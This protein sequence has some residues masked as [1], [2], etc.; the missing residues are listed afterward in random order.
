M[1]AHGKFLARMACHALILFVSATAHATDSPSLIDLRLDQENLSE[2]NRFSILPHKPNYIL[3]LSYNTQPNQAPWRTFGI[4]Q[5]PV[6]NHEVKFQVSIKLPLATN[7]L[8]EHDA[9][10]AAYTQKSFWQ[11]YNKKISSP[12]R[13]TSF[14]PELFYRMEL[15]REIAGLH[16]RILNLGF[17]HE[18][19][20]RAEPL[21]RSWNRLYATAVAEQGN[22]ALALKVWARIP[23]KAAS[24]NNPDILNYLGNEELYAIYHYE[25]HRFSLMFRPGLRAGFTPGIQL[26]WSFPLTEKIQGYVQYYSGY[27]ESLIDYNHYNNSIGIG[28]MLNN[29]L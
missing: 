4:G 29:W 25:R 16:V 14:N 12:F 2:K 8:T 13:D 18:S 10:F 22:F 26:D 23:E 5:N 17:E 21:S 1:Y 9:L 7:L 6:Q 15:D 20:G 3:P 19:N 27:G 11:A 28:L 24:D